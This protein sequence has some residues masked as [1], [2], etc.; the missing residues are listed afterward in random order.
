MKIISEGV[1]VIASSKALIT[2]YKDKKFDYNFPDGISKL[3]KEHKI[4]ALTTSEGDNLI[5]EFD[6]SKDL[7]LQCDKEFNQMLKLDMNDELLILSHSEFTQIC[8]KNGDYHNYKWPIQKIEGLSSG[9]YSVNIKVE[10]LTDRFEE[11]NA[12]FRLVI[13]MEKYKGVGIINEVKEIG[14]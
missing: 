2:E 7:K 10:N 8:D 3:L 9:T 11:F 14:H 4:I 1:L 13:Q 12:Y 6:N 5:I